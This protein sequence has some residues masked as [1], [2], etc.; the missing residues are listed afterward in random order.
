MIYVQY[1]YLFCLSISLYAVRMYIFAF[2]NTRKTHQ[3]TDTQIYLG[4]IHMA[5]GQKYWVSPNPIGNF[6]NICPQ[7]R[8]GRGILLDPLHHK[9][10]KKS[11]KENSKATRKTHQ[12]T[13]T[14]KPKSNTKK[15]PKPKENQHRAP[16]GFGFIHSE[17]ISGDIFFAKPGASTWE[18]ERI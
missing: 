9:T 6:G 11:S 16:Q 8:P 3:T 13:D 12:K 10:P 7:K 1:L 5:I 15:P 14:K 17:G 4:Y 18:G 2:P